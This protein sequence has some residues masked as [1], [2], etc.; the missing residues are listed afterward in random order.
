MLTIRVETSLWQE[1]TSVCDKCDGG[2]LQDEKH[3]VFLCSCGPMCS[4]RKTYE[5]L[6]SGFPSAHRVLKD[7]TGAFY[8]TQ[9]SCEDV[10]HF[11]QDQTNETLRFISA[12]MEIFSELSNNTDQPNYL[13]EGQ[14]LL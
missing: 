13:A 7:E 10:F 6:F 9:A 3:A 2:E 4:F 5:H 8:Y 12:L 11:L 1:H 14:T